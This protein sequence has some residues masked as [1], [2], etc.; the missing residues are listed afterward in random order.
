M[1]DQTAPAA[2]NCPRLRLV[3]LAVVPALVAAVLLVISQK[4][5]AS[6]SLWAPLTSTRPPANAARGLTARR[7]I[8]AEDHGTHSTHIDAPSPDLREEEHYVVPKHFSM[9][10]APLINRRV[11]VGSA[12]MLSVAHA[13]SA[14]AIT[15]P[16]P[17]QSSVALV[18][19]LF[20]TWASPLFCVYLSMGLLA[21]A[22]LS[23]IMNLDS[24][25]MLAVQLTV[26]TA[27]ATYAAIAVGLTVLGG[28]AGAL[29]L[30][31][32]FFLREIFKSSR[33]A[34]PSLQERIATF[35]DETSQVW[36]EV[37]GDH[38]HHGLYK[39]GVAIKTH[40]QNLDAQEDMIEE[41]LK[42][43]NVRNLEGDIK[44]LDAGCGIGGSSRSMARMFP[45]AQLTGIT[46]SPFQQQRA[47]A[48]T[49]SA[50]LSD[51]VAFRVEDAMKTSFPDNTFDV[52]YSMES[53]EHMPDKKGFVAE[54]MRVLKPGGVLVMAVW[55]HRE[56]P[57]QLNKSEVSLLEKI[58]K[59]YALPYVCA[60][61][62]FERYAK[63]LGME[64]TKFDD[65]SDSIK[66][67]WWQ[68]IKK[69]VSIQGITGLIKSGMTAIYGAWAAG[70]M[71]LAV[72]RR[73]FVFGAFTATKPA[74]I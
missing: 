43:G 41:I 50:G 3:G 8:A 46:L 44:I 53:G 73:V 37:W 35:Y 62:D 27:A 11:A 24:T 10:D 56:V 21:T 28:F 7:T 17:V 70:W 23:N 38:M 74:T 25:V 5:E 33:R 59:V 45:K 22:A 30:T 55:C 51:R 14:A 54:C 65:W 4:S 12:A 18:Q 34:D 60:L 49:A 36:E 57:P 58:Y 26:A 39:K 6:S 72:E 15:L 1:A 20:S 48:L 66:P 16:Q 31:G 13:Q 61:S 32:A 40:Q 19:T 2:F 47:T 71:Q 64:K 69:A 9:F 42:Y 63:E 68:V 67:F 29:A 52:V